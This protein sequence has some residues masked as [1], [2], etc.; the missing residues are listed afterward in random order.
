M[1]ILNTSNMTFSAL[2]R[3]VEA[4]DKVME[5]ND[6]SNR[7]RNDLIGEYAYRYAEKDMPKLLDEAIARCQY[8]EDIHPTATSIV[9]KITG[10]VRPFSPAVYS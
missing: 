4:V 5:A 8:G 7:E 6:L 3:F 10:E 9:D 1:T 2:K